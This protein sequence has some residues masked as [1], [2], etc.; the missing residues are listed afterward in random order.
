MLKTIESESLIKRKRVIEHLPFRPLPGFSSPHL[1]TVLPTF[2]SQAGEAPPSAPFL[3]SLEDGDTLYCRISSPLSWKPQDKT[4]I[5]VHGLGGDADTSNYMVRMSRKLYRS[6]Y[7][8]IRMNLRY[9]GEGNQYAK[10]PYHGGTSHDL[11]ALVRALKDQSPQSP[12][13]II[14]YSLGGNITLKMVGELKEKA[15]SL[16]EMVIAV[17]APIDLQH[18]MELLKH[19]TNQLYHRYYVKALRK[20]G[21]PWIG[22]QS[23]KSIL[24]FDNVVTAPQWG[25]K[26]AFDYYRQCS[27]QYFLSGIQQTCHLIFAE[28]DPFIDYRP[29]LKQLHSPNMKLWLSPHGGH[30]GFWGWAGKEH[31]HYWLDRFLLKIIREH[32]EHII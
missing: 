17:C 7:R 23:V 19:P 4:V 24:D 11:L 21:Q 29:A 8:S 20:V 10:R 1:Q 30:M 2:F 31:R 22:K 27:S 25:F 3:V 12:I 9:A 16:I 18:T 6:G 14:G 28:D 13:T 32:E 26:D 5:L 15:H